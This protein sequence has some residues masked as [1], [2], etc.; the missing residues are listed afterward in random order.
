MI[1]SV[2][3]FAQR[4]H[5][6]YELMVIWHLGWDACVSDADTTICSIVFVLLITTVYGNTSQILNDVQS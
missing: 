6:W 4:C 2:L 1:N 5:E 3:D